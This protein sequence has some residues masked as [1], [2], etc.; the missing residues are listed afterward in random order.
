MHYTYCIKYNSYNMSPQYAIRSGKIQHFADSIKIAIYSIYNVQITSLLSMS[1]CNNCTVSELQHFVTQPLILPILRV[2]KF[3]NAYSRQWIFKDRS[4]Y[5][6][7]GTCMLWPTHANLCTFAYTL[8]TVA[9]SVLLELNEANPRIG[10][11][12]CR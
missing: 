2:V 8:S 9:K 10:N 1:I 7:R 12:L 11:G 5:C 3:C 4:Q 6:F